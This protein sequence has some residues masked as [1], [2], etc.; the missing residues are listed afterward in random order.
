MAEN[1][2]SVTAEA[3]EQGSVLDLQ[4][5]SKDMDRC[6]MSCISFVSTF[7]MSTRK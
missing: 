5:L 4:G 2:E 1:I 3:E 6:E 7:D